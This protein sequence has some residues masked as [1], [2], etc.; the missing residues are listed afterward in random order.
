MM[1]S[2]DILEQFR[3]D[4]ARDNATDINL[5]LRPVYLDLL[6]KLG[7]PHQ[8]CPPVFHIAGTNGKGST[9]AFLRAIL[10]ASGYRVHV[11]TS[12]HLVRF[13]ERIRVAGDLIPES[14]LVSLLQECQTHSLP[15]QLSY[16][17]I[18]TAIAF[19]AFARAPADFTLLETG[20]GGRLDATN[21]VDQPLAT[22]ITRLSYDHRDYL[23]TT[24]REIAGEKAGIMRSSVPCFVA[25]QPNHESLEAL[26]EAAAAKGAFLKVGG[27]D[28]TTTPNANGFHYQDA[29][30]HFD[31][32]FPALLGV[33]QFSNA[34]LAIAA[35]SVL[36]H[37]PDL[38][39][40]CQGLRQVEWPARL[41]HLTT[42]K[43][44]EMLP[45]ATE[46]WLDGGHNDSAGEVLAL[47]IQRWRDEDGQ[48]G[49]ITGCLMA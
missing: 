12:P 5:T 37:P 27:R 1:L 23:G 35:L 36:P 15:G 20:L 19:T 30:R 17:E 9:C 24:L 4:H 11:Y 13:H 8:K 26:Q 46:L 49:M 33:H 22:L 40:I 3:R 21:V 32:P 2:A 44:P 39:E 16:F 31:L 42:G 38:P 43:L 41:Q 34:G 28:W 45:P 29:E 47:Q 14:L 18:A 48:N 6:D 7:N 25:P 10:E